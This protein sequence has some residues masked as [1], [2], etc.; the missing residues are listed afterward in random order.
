[1]LTRRQLLERAASLGAGAPVMGLAPL[2]WPGGQAREPAAPRARYWATAPAADGECLQCHPAGQKLA[3]GYRHQPAAVACLLCAHRCRIP[4]GGRGACRARA[5]VGG[6]LR[7]L[8][9]GR[10]LS[11]T[12]DP[13]EKKPFYHVLPGSEALSFG[14]SGCPLRCRFCQN[15]E[16]SQ[17]SPGDFSPA[18]RPPADVVRAA[19]LR[20]SPVI[21]FTY[22]EPTVFTEYALDIATEASRRKVRC[23]M[24]SCGLMNDAPL[25]DLCSALAAIKIDLK[26]YSESFY[27]DVCGGELRPVLRTIR[28]VASG[29]THLEI[30]N[31]VVPTLND[32]DRG[33]RDLVSFVAGE[34]GPDVPLHFSRFYPDY[35]LKHLPPTPIAALDRAR[36]LALAAGLHYVYVGNVPGH[37]GNHT[38]CPGCRKVVLRREGFF[39]TEN[40]LKGGR[41]G[42]CETPI[43]GVWA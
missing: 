12:V 27:R 38:Y 30:V 21:A 15:W 9:Y 41:C 3:R 6:E 36:D 34:L 4:P 33:L 43:K 18:Y 22:N 11:I 42:Y 23:V 25:R 16:L 28:Q 40:H 20:H 13:I 10:P 35:Q 26:G 2:A 29:R 19:E 5:N 31:L 1:M 39:V 37:A 17:S 32:S 24:V 7:S 8:V 14:T